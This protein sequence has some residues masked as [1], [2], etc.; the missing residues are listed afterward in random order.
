MPHNTVMFS[1]ADV[2]TSS[3]VD[4]DSV[5]NGSCLKT[6]VK[7]GLSDWRC[8]A[9][10]LPLWL[11]HCISLWCGLG[12]KYLRQVL[13]RCLNDRNAQTCTASLMNV[14][15]V[16]VWY[17]LRWN[18]PA[19][20]ITVVIRSWC[21]VSLMLWYDSHWSTSLFFELCVS[22]LSLNSFAYSFPS[23]S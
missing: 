22:L 13:R 16:N 15:L 21:L 17:L 5:V 12:P 6:V 23:N 7:G 11:D 18:E 20:L 19:E 9:V 14:M 8:W 10:W 1:K 2:K 3:H 4:R